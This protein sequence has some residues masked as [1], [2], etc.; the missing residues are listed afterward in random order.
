MAFCKLCNTNLEAKLSDQKRHVN[1]KKYSDNTGL[2]HTH[3]TGHQ[4]E[5][6]MIHLYFI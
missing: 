3:D 2:P 4:G 1:T 6:R 5:K